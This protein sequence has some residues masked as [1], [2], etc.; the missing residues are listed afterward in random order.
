MRVGGGIGVL[1]FALIGAL[2][3]A[4][5]GCAGMN[6]GMGIG[7]SPEA[8]RTRTIVVHVHPS[9]RVATLFHAIAGGYRE[10]GEEDKADF[11]DGHVSDGFGSGFL[12][13]QGDAMFAVTNRHV[14]DLG[15]APE[16]EIEGSQERL[17]AEV[18]YTDP[19][20][21]L[22]II[23]PKSGT[24]WPVG[25]GPMNLAM[26]PARDL[27]N[28]IATG[29]PA[30][31]GNPSYQ[32]TQGNVSNA[33]V[34]LGGVTFIQHSAPIDPGSSGG[35][36]LNSSGSV[37]GVNTGKAPGRDNVYLAVPAK[38]VREALVHAGAATAARITAGWE[39]QSLRAACRSLA[40]GL[41]AED[42][43][44]STVFSIGD[45]LVAERGFESLR[46]VDTDQRT[47]THDRQ[48]LRAAF[49]REPVALLRL[50]VAVRLFAEAHEVDG[51]AVA[52]T[53]KEEPNAE[54]VAKLTMQFQNRTRETV[55]RFE[56]GQWRLAAIA[57][58]RGTP[59][60]GTATA[61]V[62]AKDA[63]PKAKDK[64]AKDKSKPARPREVVQ[65]EAPRRVR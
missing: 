8:L 64:G 31:N 18:V 56:Q 28:V 53:T 16:L 41:T 63:A 35:P 19:L 58:L 25:L 2:S 37:I 4:T 29:Y 39:G 65:E 46:V 17:P 12:V 3:P 30:L 40:T 26:S 20:Y 27:D 47:T 24:T 36:L 51:P 60:P 10:R 50:S 42:L 9:K 21:D 15:D 49:T 1:A 45:D 5:T 34:P 33:N 23:A 62:Q 43:A 6:L 14:V 55:W 54:H 48:L 44:P 13:R 38:A 57:G 52:C 61:A 22:A 59:I 7:T 32:S 11:F